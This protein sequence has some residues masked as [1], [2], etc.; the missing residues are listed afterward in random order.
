MQQGVFVTAFAG[1]SAGAVTSAAVYN[2]AKK[3]APSVWWERWETWSAFT[4]G[5]T[6]VLAGRSHF[7]VPEAFKSIYPPQ[8]TWGFWYLP[9]SSDFHVAWT[10]VAELLGG[11]GLLLGCL[12]SIAGQP[13]GPTL[14][15]WAA[16]SVLLLVLTVSPANIYMFTH[17]AIMPGIVEGELPVGWHAGRFIAQ[18]IV[19]SVLLTIS[20]APTGAAEE[21]A[22][23]EAGG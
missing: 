3:A 4:L 20:E 16:R 5:V 9:G 2:A 6:F 23:T 18:V 11:S 15:S 13:R 17:G 21:E 14:L 12:L 7:T 8:G 19:L 1:L 22:R 10:G